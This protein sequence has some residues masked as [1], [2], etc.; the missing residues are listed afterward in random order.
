MKSFNPYEVLNVKQ[1]A[2][3]DEIRKAYRAL[4]RKYHPDSNP[5]D[6]V[7]EEKFKQISEAYDILS[8]DVKK[9]DYD[10]EQRQTSSAGTGRGTAGGVK[11]QPAQRRT[12]SQG[13]KVDMGEE[14]KKSQQQFNDFFG[15]KF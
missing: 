3:K 9:A 11:K 8:D 7:A 13:T 15:F 4:A 2:T 14:F 12:G 6:K 5:G 1:G 10:R